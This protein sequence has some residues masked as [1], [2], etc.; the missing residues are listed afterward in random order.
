MRKEDKEWAVSSQWSPGD[1]QCS[2]E[3]RAGPEL[4]HHGSLSSRLLVHSTGILVSLNQRKT[5]SRYRHVWHK[6]FS[7][8]LI[9]ATLDSILETNIRSEPEVSQF[10]TWNMYSQ[11]TPLTWE[12]IRVPGFELSW[13]YTLVIL[14]ICMDHWTFDGK[15]SPPDACLFTHSSKNGHHPDILTSFL[16]RTNEHS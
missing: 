5:G 7:P 15:Q 2:S 4:Q 14:M 10:W 13:K 6:S 9:Y 1:R 11:K 3:Q 8:G 16:T 12:A